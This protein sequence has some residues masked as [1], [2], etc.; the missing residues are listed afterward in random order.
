MEHLVRFAS[1]QQFIAWVSDVLV[2]SCG[3]WCAYTPVCVCVCVSQHPVAVSGFSQ[4][5]TGAA[6]TFCRVVVCGQRKRNVKRLKYK[7]FQFNFT[8]W[9]ET[10]RM[11]ECAEHRRSTPD[12]YKS[13]FLSFI[14]TL[15][16]RNLR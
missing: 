3:M 7:M 9:V 1:F 15:S 5:L 13:L 10:D 11:V 8:S 2:Y 4:V 6:A 16:Q 12:I 14:H